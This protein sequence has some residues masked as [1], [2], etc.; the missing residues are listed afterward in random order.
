LRDGL[1]QPAEESAD[2][3][4]IKVDRNELHS[5][6]GTAAPYF[7]RIVCCLL[8]R[9]RALFGMGQMERKEVRVPWQKDQKKGKQPGIED[10]R[11][12]AQ[13]TKANINWPELSVE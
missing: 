5:F 9:R 12:L 2:P 10:V 7:L 6:Q 1:G 3:K 8:M 4:N 11:H 13:M